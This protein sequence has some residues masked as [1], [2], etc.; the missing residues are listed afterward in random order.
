MPTATMPVTER[1][2][3]KITGNKSDVWFDAD[4]T[5][6]QH[7]VELPVDPKTHKINARLYACVVA[8]CPSAE[9]LTAPATELAEGK[10]FCPRDG[11]P[12]SYV[13]LDPSQDDPIAHGRQ[14]QLARIAAFWANKRRNYAQAVLASA[15]VRTVVDTKQALPGQVATLAKDGQKHLPSLAAAAVIEIGV[16]YTV[17]LRGATAG[18]ALTA[19]CT[20]GALAGYWLAVQ[21]EKLRMRLRKEGF[22]GRAAK[23]ARERGLWAGMGVAGTGVFL[24]AVSAIEGLCGLDAGAG[25]QW[26]LLS[27]LGL[28]LAWLVNRGH[29]DRLWAERRRIRDLATDNARR[30]A[31]AEADR[32]M[33]DAARAMEE[34]RLREELAEVGAYDENNPTDQGQRMRIE[35]ERIGR[36]PTAAANFPQ[37]TKTKIIPERTREITAPDPND[38]K[39]KRIGWEYLGQAEPGALVGRGGMGSPLLSAKEWVVA[40]LFDGQYDP[41]AIS[42]VDNPGGAQNTFLIMVTEQARLGDAVPWNPDTAVRIT[43]GGHLRY[44]YLGRALT[45]EDLEEVL[46]TRGQPIG[47]MVSGT[48]GG[49]KGGFA[50]R[51]ILNCL[52]ARMFPI[53]FDPKGLVDY[54]DFAGVFPIGFTK[55][56]RR[57]ILEFLVRERERRQAV[58]AAAPRTNKYGAKVAGES[59][60]DTCDPITGEIGRYGEPI[61]TVWDEFHDLSKDTKF[62]LEFTNHVRFQRVAAI[63]ALM[64]SQGGGLED[65][66][67]STLRDLVNGT[68]L[69]LFRTGDLNSRMAGGRNQTYSTADLPMLPGMCLRQAPGA[70]NVPM[71]AAFISR[72]A[73]AEDT[74]FTTL[75]GKGAEPQ[76]QIEDPLT[77]IS[78]ETIAIMKDTGLWDIWMQARAAGGSFDPVGGLDRLLADLV[79][80]EEDEDGEVVVYRQPSAPSRPAE[81]AVV[82]QPG[83]GRMPARNV[84]L[85]ILHET[86]GLGREEILAHDAWFRA[87]GWAGPPSDQQLTRAA[88]DLDPTVGGRESLPDG[89]VQK[90]NRGPKSGSW[91]LTEAG[92]QDAAWAFAQL[93]PRE[94]ASPVSPA[95]PHASQ[96]MSSNAVTIAEMAAQRAAEM[97]MV[98]AEETRMAARG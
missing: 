28:G 37:I 47:G 30:A 33:R 42:L 24:A 95:G 59:K 51:Y 89:R 75:W 29:W 67:N 79:E 20:W 45:G 93:R 54:G 92:Q 56:H 36:L 57:I 84:I 58:T 50:T 2:L 46:Y 34:A 85:S 69:T 87:P 97:A 17:D 14:K 62:L 11:Q 39:P 63:G 27:L 76:L 16:V 80:D 61:A 83:G 40:V 23:K 72:D 68:S 66:G 52:K 65:W 64:L 77:W 78:V 55:R 22:E 7:A 81:K 9:W 10:K 60:W 94:V 90:I 98:I 35:W 19:M 41:A 71:R 1:P 8:S 31:Q 38:G 53:V 44:G 15:P 26:A 82:Q 88:K 48:T 21:A 96:D 6:R 74:I 3:P 86:P 73:E 49:G 12:L 13:P 43:N 25:W 18:F 4:G 32:A 70:L 91:T 5:L